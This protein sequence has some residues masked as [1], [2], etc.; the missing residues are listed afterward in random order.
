M[1][2]IYCQYSY[3]GYKT[4]FL[5]GEANEEVA[6]EVTND[7]PFDFPADAH[8]FFQFGGTKMAYKQLHN[9]EHTLVLREIPSI[10][11]DSDGRS[12]PCALQLIGQDEDRKALDNLAVVIADDLQ[13]FETFFSKLFYVKQGLHIHGDKLREYL[14]RS[15][16][17]LVF[18]GEV[19]PTLKN[20]AGNTDK[21]HLFVPLSTKFGIDNEV[22]HRTRVNLQLEAVRNYITLSELIGIQHKAL[23][24]IGPL[25]QTISTPEQQ[26]TSTSPTEPDEKD[27]IISSLKQE[28]AELTEKYNNAFDNLKKLREKLEEKDE[29]IN[30][31]SNELQKKKTL[32]KYILV[33]CGILF[34]LLIIATCSGS[35][36]NEVGAKIQSECINDS[37]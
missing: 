33:G 11:T 28:K 30:S 23:P 35:R 17:D 2:R 1:I 29:V 25:P 18:M 22:T 9:G 8:L 7:T 16:G 27:R 21:V 13:A 3:G 10:H 37:L 19:H 5:R 6:N 36:S 32:I 12:I 34:L 14:C 20:V 4:F 31:L 24:Q 26:A 15:Y